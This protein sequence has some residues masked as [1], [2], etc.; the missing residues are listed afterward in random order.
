MGKE[1]AIKL[2]SQYVEHFDATASVEE[3]LYSLIVEK[4]IDKT[5]LRN[6]LVIRDYDLLRKANNCTITSIYDQLAADYNCSQPNIKYIITKRKYNEI[7]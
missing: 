3:V 6:A 2:L 4:K 5:R 7:R 1:E